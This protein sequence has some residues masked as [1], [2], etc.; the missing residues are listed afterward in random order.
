[1]EYVHFKGNTAVWKLMWPVIVMELPPDSSD[2]D[3]NASA[4]IASLAFTEY[5]F[6]FERIHIE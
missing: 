2:R 6:V 4:C 1:L 5:K 3:S